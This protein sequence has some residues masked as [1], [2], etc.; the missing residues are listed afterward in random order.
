MVWIAPAI[1]TVVMSGASIFHAAMPSAALAEGVVPS[2]MAGPVMA[3]SPRM[4]DRTQPLWAPALTL[5]AGSQR[6]EQ[7]RLAVRPDGTYT[8]V[9]VELDGVDTPPSD[10]SQ[11]V[12][13]VDVDSGGVSD[14]VVIGGV[15][16]SM[17]EPNHSDDPELGLQVAVDSAGLTTVVWSESRTDDQGDMWGP[18]VLEVH[19]PNDGEW[20][21]PE[22]L[23]RR[24]G[25][26]PKLAV[27]PAGHALVVWNSWG[28]GHGFSRFRTPDGPWRA[29]VPTP[30]DASSSSIGC[31]QRWRGQGGDPL[32]RSPGETTG[33]RRLPLG[34]ADQALAR[35]LWKVSTW[36]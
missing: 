13:A 30:I 3:P 8:V 9:W 33:R 10:N 22:K 12:M 16:G 24:R 27:S 35:A 17:I 18:H 6:I 20:S 26:Y 19:R 31:G 14:P 36:P 4:T 34:H 32:A 23:S 1:G 28:R 2:A 25:V 7:V 29:Q 21:T 5:A 15:P 11:R